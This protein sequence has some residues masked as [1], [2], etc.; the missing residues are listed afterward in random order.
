LLDLRRKNRE[1]LIAFIRSHDPAALPR[2]LTDV[3]ASSPALQQRPYLSQCAEQR[4]ELF[5]RGL[6]LMF[7]GRHEMVGRLLEK[8]DGTLQLLAQI[9]R[10]PICGP[11]Q[12]HAEVGDLGT[13]ALDL[14]AQHFELAKEG[15]LGEWLGISHDR[16]A[17][18]TEAA[19]DST[20][21]GVNAE[22]RVAAALARVGAINSSC[23][24]CGTP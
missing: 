7:G 21:D 3:M 11:L 24:G 13:H 15:Q 23:C 18:R 22:G 1:K 5:T 19:R 8:G 2:L 17:Q 10:T 4:L 14:V 20:A 12:R 9:E 6:I 16:C